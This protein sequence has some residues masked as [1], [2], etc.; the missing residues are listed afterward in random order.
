MS[1][2]IPT[3]TGAAPTVP[4]VPA[5]PLESAVDAWGA[6]AT[7]WGDAD[8]EM[9]DWGAETTSEWSTAGGND[10]TAAGGGGTAASIDA[11]LDAQER[12]STQTT[13]S[14]AEGLQVSGVEKQSP[15]VAADSRTEG[16]E[17][18]AEHHAEQTV[19]STEVGTRDCRFF[20]SKLMN[21][22]PEPWADSSSVDDTDMENRL[23]RYREEEEDRG[24]VAALD[25]A[26]G[27]KGSAVG[28]KQGAGAVL[29]GVG[30]KYERTP[31][32]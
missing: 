26:L 10:G 18:A 3:V 14:Q 13:Y 2:S 16:K 4:P 21:F 12:R 7:S 30:E 19:P 23:R 31:A 22:S 11:L 28:D 25:Q 15:T 29:A 32:R 17:A 8:E 27:L 6:N 24:L 5:R 9:D 1:S 20:P